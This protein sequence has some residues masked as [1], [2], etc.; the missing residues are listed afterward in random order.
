MGF[1]FLPILYF[2]REIKKLYILTILVTN[3]T[4]E[5]TSKRI[6][7]TVTGTKEI[8]KRKCFRTQIPNIFICLETTQAAALINTGKINI[9]KKDLALSEIGSNAVAHLQITDTNRTP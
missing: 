9:E 4:K 7:L 8:C 5:Q 3:I 6:A 2:D 1:L